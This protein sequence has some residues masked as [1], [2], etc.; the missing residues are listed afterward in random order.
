M[1]QKK[2]DGVHNLKGEEESCTAFEVGKE[3]L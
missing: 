1:R 3:A 2:Q